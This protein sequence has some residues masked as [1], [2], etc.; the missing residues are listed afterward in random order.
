M[1]VNMRVL[2]LHHLC[3]RHRPCPGT[4]GHQN[5]A[6]ESGHGG[7]DA[8]VGKG[9]SGEC[10]ELVAVGRD[11]DGDAAVGYRTEIKKEAFTRRPDVWR[12]GTDPLLPFG[13]VRDF[14]V[15]EFGTVRRDGEQSEQTQRLSRSNRP[16]NPFLISSSSCLLSSSV[17]RFSSRRLITGSRRRQS[18]STVGFCRVP[19]TCT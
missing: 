2:V 8:P 11:V 13:P 6:A 16:S 9:R 1:Q 5:D 14:T 3:V 12:R 18:S 7:G 19:P 4:G 10:Q 15:P 17:T